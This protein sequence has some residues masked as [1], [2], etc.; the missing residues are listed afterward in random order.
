MADIFTKAMGMDSEAHNL[1]VHGID[2]L[3][4]EAADDI[5]VFV[6]P[7]YAGRV[8]ALAAERFMAVNGHGQKAIA[9]AVY[10]NR[11]YDDALVELCDIISARGFKLIAAAAFIAQHCIFPKVATDRPDASD[12]TKLARFASLV[13]ERIG[14]GTLLDLKTVKGNRPYKKPAGVPLHPQA[15]KKKCNDCGTCAAQCPTGA[16]DASDPKK[17]DAKLCIAC[18]RCINVCPQDAR[19]FAGMLYKVAGWKFCK[20]NSRRLEPEWFV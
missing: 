15:D 19:S 18:C 9:I 5:S 1:T 2:R 12:E 20:D 4:I 7:V 3:D 8:P 16:I 6:A 13:R 10:G 17:T 14:S 11:D